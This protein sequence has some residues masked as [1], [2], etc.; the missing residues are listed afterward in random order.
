MMEN[1]KKE[2]SILLEKDSSG[3]GMD[4]I[5]RVIELSKK[6]AK[7]QNANLEEV[8]LIALLHDVDD[9]KL[10]DKEQAENLTNAKNIMQK[11]NINEEMQIKVLK[12]L[13]AIGYSKSLKGIRPDSIEGKI[14]SDADMCDAMGINGILRSHTYNMKQGKPFFNK[15]IYPIENISAEQYKNK[16]ADTSVCHIFEKTLKLKDLMMTN[17]GKEEGIKRH[18]TTINFLYSLFEEENANEWIVYLNNFLNS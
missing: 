1:V 5:N 14:V 12:S 15:N 13:G 17:S 6:F 18:K 3:H 7:K 8:S 9:Y 16:T 10:V 11:C 4:H 2:V